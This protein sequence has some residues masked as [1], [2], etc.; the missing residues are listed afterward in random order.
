M[1]VDWIAYSFETDTDEQNTN[2]HD[3][4]TVFRG[5]ELNDT[6]LPEQVTV[7]IYTNKDARQMRRYAN[8]LET[9]LRRNKE[10]YS[11]YGENTIKR[12]IEWLRYWSERNKN[13]EAWY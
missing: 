8:E 6:S 5:E 9:E 11:K 7:E 2:N 12:A 1:G 4:S 13:M 3:Y 10:T